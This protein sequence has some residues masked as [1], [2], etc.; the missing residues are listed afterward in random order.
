MSRKDQSSK[1][2]KKF[3]S[4]KLVT[5]N[6]GSSRKSSDE[7]NDEQLERIAGGVSYAYHGLE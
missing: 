1:S 3:E 6:S 4:K 7:L 2:T 5:K